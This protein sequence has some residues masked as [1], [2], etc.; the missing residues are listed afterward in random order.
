MARAF[1][2]RDDELRDGS[3]AIFRHIVEQL[4]EL[5]SPGWPLREC[6]P[7]EHTFCF[8]SFTERAT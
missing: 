1:S 7:I 8:C 2:D 6:E 5:I 3:P 4:L